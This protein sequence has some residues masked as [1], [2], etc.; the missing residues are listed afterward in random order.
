M[1]LNE[2]IEI[3]DGL[4]NKLHEIRSRGK[5]QDRLGNS[6]IFEK[7]PIFDWKSGIPVWE[8][9]LPPASEVFKYKYEIHTPTISLSGLGVD[10]WKDAVTLSFHTSSIKSHLLGIL[11]LPQL[12]FIDR[13]YETHVQ[14]LSGIVFGDEYEFFVQEAQQLSS[15]LNIIQKYLGSKNILRCQRELMTSGFIQYAQL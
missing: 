1:N 8:T 4:Q 15:V 14:L 6:I 11:E 12:R 13:A 2:V 9:V 7:H 3:P 10:F 5:L